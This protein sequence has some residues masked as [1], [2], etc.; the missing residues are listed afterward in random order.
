MKKITTEQM[1]ENVTNSLVADITALS[2]Q[3]D[4]AISVFCKTANDS[5]SINESLASKLNNLEEF[6]AFIEQQKVATTQ[7]INDNQ[8]VRSRIIDIIGE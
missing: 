6:S 1:I 2:T 8:V 7:M 4:A 3:K 5:S